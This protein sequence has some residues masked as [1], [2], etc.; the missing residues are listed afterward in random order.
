MLRAR[1][2]GRAVADAPARP[3]HA[4][5]A[6]LP[7]RI[8]GVVGGAVP[9]VVLGDGSK[10]QPGGRRD[11]WRLVAVES[12]RLVFDGPRSLVVLR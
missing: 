2:V 6:P 11:G 1:E 5:A 8:R 7:F 4:S 12:D 3:V 9:Y 10:L